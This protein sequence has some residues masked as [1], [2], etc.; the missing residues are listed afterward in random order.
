LKAGG[1]PT[2]TSVHDPVG[3][4]LITGVVASRTDASLDSFMSDG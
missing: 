4:V 2:A 3:S 1:K